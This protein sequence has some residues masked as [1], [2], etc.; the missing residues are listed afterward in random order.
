MQASVGIVSRFGRRALSIYFVCTPKSFVRQL[1]SQSL[2]DSSL[3]V[4]GF[5]YS[6][7]SRKR[8]LSRLSAGYQQ[9]TTKHQS[10]RRE[11]P[12]KS[13][14]EQKEPIFNQGSLRFYATCHP[15]AICQGFD[16]LSLYLQG[17][18]MCESSSSLLRSKP[19]LQAW[20][21]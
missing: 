17:I 4:R 13:K 18:F 11:I 1:N 8:G 5:E 6:C 12:D 20:S 15:G 10:P 19:L 3:R 16:C 7:P 21:R 9:R 14:Q 2:H